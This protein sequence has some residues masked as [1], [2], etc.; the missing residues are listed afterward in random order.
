MCDHVESDR[1]VVATHTPDIGRILIQEAAEPGRVFH[2]I[3]SPV[4]VELET[5]VV[6]FSVVHRAG[7]SQLR[8]PVPADAERGENVNVRA[9]VQLQD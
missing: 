7:L 6:L 2:Q 3:A 4:V 9:K 8:V 1:L 5:G